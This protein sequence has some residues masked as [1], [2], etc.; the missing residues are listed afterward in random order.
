MALPTFILLYKYPHPPS[1]ELLSFSS[2][3]LY[4]LT[5]CPQPLET[6]LFLSSLD[7]CVSGIVQYLYF[8]DWLISL[9]LVTSGFIHVMGMFE[10]Y[11]SFKGWIVSRCLFIHTI[12]CFSF[13]CQW[14]VEFLRPLSDVN[15]GA[16]KWLYKYVSVSAFKYFGYL[17]WGGIDRSYI[18]FKFLRSY[19]I[20]FHSDICIA[21]QKSSQ[22][23]CKVAVCPF[24]Q[25]WKIVS[26]VSHTCIS[27]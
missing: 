27:W 9:S 22:M 15:N 1:P 11:L 17:Y 16:M 8:Y 2:E 14:V 12:S 10:S 3:T 25:Q 18:N 13:T 21:L 6:T 5:W 24:H 20:V 4:L 19:H 26:V 23:S 7:I